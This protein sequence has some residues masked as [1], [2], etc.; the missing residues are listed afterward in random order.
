MPDL[1]PGAAAAETPP[2]PGPYTSTETRTFEIHGPLK[3]TITTKYDSSHVP[4]SSSKVESAGPDLFE[5]LKPLAE[6]IMRKLDE[7]QRA[8]NAESA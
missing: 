5:M 4:P 1:L 6:I 2:E 8:Q 3:I 7:I